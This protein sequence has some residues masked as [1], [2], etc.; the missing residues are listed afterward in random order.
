MKLLL[1][2]HS[3]PYGKQETFL[4]L[5]IDVLSQIEDLEITIVPRVLSPEKRKISSNISI[6]TSYSEYLIKNSEKKIYPVLNIDLLV[7]QLLGMSP[8]LFITAVISLIGP[9][10]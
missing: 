4:E 5:E 10:K 8:L 6:D 9:K 2:T 1:F 7:F 3:F